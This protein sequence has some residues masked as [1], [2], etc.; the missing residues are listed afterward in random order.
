MN[1][2]SG[3]ENS[4]IA[5]DH[6]KRQC[7]QRAAGVAYRQMAAVDGK[8]IAQVDGEAGTFSGNGASGPENGLIDEALLVF[9]AADG[10]VKGEENQDVGSQSDASQTRHDGSNGS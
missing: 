2:D 10:R 7:Q 6:V 5:A 9:N 4:L 1:Q 8:E 3:K